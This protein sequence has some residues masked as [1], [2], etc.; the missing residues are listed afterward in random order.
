MLAE[1]RVAFRRRVER[2][3]RVR[4]SHSRMETLL[5]EAGAPPERLHRIPLGISL[6]LFPQTTPELRREA[7]RSLQLPEA[8]VVVGSFQKDG[9][10]WGEGLEPKRIKGPDVLLAAVEILKARIPELS[11][12]LSGPAR[13]YVRRGLERLGV[14][15]R[16]VWLERARDV[17]ACYQALDVYLVPSRD[18]GGPKAVLEAMASGVPLVTTRVGQARDLVRH[19]ENGFMIEPEDAEGLAHWAAALLGDAALRGRV[20]AEGRTTAEAHSY[21][22]QR[23]LWERFFEGYLERP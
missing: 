9:V 12:L 16:H 22:A 6:G 8:A 18:E 11:V 20:V 2:L 13:G 21:D 1:L 15:H 7:R 19:G 14:P 4:V 23:P 5:L 3:H 10:G 17:A